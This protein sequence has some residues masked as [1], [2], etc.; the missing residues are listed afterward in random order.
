MSVCTA[1]QAPD[2]LADIELVDEALAVAGIEL[3]ASAIYRLIQS[4]QANAA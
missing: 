2:A 4:V 3:N 1:S